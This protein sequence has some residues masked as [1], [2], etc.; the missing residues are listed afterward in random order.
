MTRCWEGPLGAVRPLEAPSW[1]IAEP[2]TTASTWWPLRSASES[3]S[4]SSRPTPSDQPA[5]S[6]AAENALQRP[7]EAEPPCRPNSMK[8]VGVDMT[9]TPP[10]RARSHSPARSACTARWRET[11]EAEQAVSTETA[12]PSKPRA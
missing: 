6:A 9:V 3:R 8:T 1:L 2:R 11:R 12:G 7:S 10:A 5:P 4:T